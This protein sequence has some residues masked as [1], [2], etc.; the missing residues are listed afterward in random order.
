M[1]G[2]RRGTATIASKVPAAVP[3]APPVAVAHH[4][5]LAL[6]Q[7]EPNAAGFQHPNIACLA[8]CRR[9]FPERAGGAKRPLGVY[10][11]GQS[12]QAPARTLVGCWRGTEGSLVASAWLVDTSCGK[13]TCFTTVGSTCKVRQRLGGRFEAPIEFVKAK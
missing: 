7:A 8:A 10:P 13:G 2:V 3:L 12:H 11:S 4:W 5:V 1:G 6:P 9:W